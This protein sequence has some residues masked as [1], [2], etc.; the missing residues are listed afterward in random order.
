MAKFLNTDL[1]NE[2]I[3]RLIDETERELIIIVPYIKTSNLMYKHLH[4]ANKRGVETTIVYRE[5]QLTP[6]EKKKFEALDN[7]N[8]MHHPNIH[9][10]CY[11]NEKYM[12]IG[13]MNL[14]EYSEKNNREM[15]VLMH[16]V[17]IEENNG[18]GS[19]ADDDTIFEDAIKEMQTIIKS[20]TFEKQSRETRTEGFEIDII[21]T[22]KELIEED[23]KILNKVFL[24]KKFAAKEVRGMWQCVCENYFDHIDVLLEYRR[25]AIDFDYKDDR[26]NDIFKRVIPNYHELRFEGYKFYWNGPKSSIYL[27]PNRQNKMWENLPQGG[28]AQLMKNGIDQVITFLRPFI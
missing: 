27:Y 16:R 8:L 15:G 21:K 26:V 14:Y 10:K 18:F 6:L 24:H 1:L 20:S 5:N 9:A 7:L 23:C 11:Y 22:Q 25:A 19:N 4:D 17:E 12:I 28:Y 3:P 2:W 13:S